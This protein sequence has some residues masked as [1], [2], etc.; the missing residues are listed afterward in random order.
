MRGHSN[1]NVFSGACV[2]IEGGS[3]P[4]FHNREVESAA[5]VA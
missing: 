3:E 2:D 4:G 5:I 1:V